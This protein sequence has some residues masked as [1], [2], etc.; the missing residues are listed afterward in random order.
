MIAQDSIAL[1]TLAS[2][3]TG[4][5]CLVLARALLHKLTARAEFAAT[6]TE[7]RILP[8]SWSKAAA[9]GLEALE[10]IAIV[11]II[12]P[13]SRQ[14]GAVLAA[15]LFSL[16]SLAM[17]I[18]LVRGRDR[19]DCGCGGAGQHLS[20]FLVGRNLLLVAACACI[21]TCDMPAMLGVAECAA[22]AGLVPL[23]WLLLVL[24]DRILGNRS[25]ERATSREA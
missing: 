15:G 22:A 16:Y 20:W 21:V 3:A 19:I 13:A 25:H 2:V 1:A 24:F 17:A 18:N 9:V 14:A 11:A 12:A 10:A 6:L 5:V 8:E 7:Y 23:L 4:L